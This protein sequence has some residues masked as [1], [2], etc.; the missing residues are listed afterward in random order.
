VPVNRGPSF[1][2]CSTA[3]VAAVVAD[4]EAREQREDAHRRWFEEASRAVQRRPDRIALQTLPN[5]SGKR[6]PD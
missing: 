2:S 1:A 5:G 3:I 4:I 6:S